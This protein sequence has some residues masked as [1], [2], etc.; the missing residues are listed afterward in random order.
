MRGRQGGEKKG[1][2]KEAVVTVAVMKNIKRDRG[3]NE[4][5]LHLV[6]H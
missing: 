2:N 4:F 5:L 1:L 3:G 6:N